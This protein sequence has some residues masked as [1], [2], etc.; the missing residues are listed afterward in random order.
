MF[1]ANTEDTCILTKTNKTPSKSVL[2][3]K[4]DLPLLED[5]LWSSI[6]CCTLQKCLD[7]FQSVYPFIYVFGG[8]FVLFF[9]GEIQGHFRQG[10]VF[11]Y[12]ICQSSIAGRTFSWEKTSDFSSF[13]LFST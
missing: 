2:Q 3:I 10:F 11:I 8:F 7:T 6:A 4:N 9:R 5:S 13:V 12:I 1:T